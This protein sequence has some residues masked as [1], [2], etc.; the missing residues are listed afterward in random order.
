MVEV[1]IPPSQMAQNA[2]E[3]QWRFEEF[4]KLNF[5][6]LRKTLFSLANESL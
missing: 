6:N 3:R 5:S 4:V 1:F 2:L